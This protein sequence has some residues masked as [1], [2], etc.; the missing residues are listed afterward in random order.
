MSLALSGILADFTRR[1]GRCVIAGGAVRD[2]L[3]LR[4]PKDYDVFVMQESLNDG[5]ARDLET[6]TSPEWHKS[7]PFLQGTVRWGAAIVQVM[8]TK[9]TS[10]KDLVGDF[11]WNV[12]MFGFDDDGFY[13]GAPIED[14]ANGK[15]LKLNKV[16]FP[17]ST[18]RRGFRFSERFGMVLPARTLAD[19][20]E[21]A[22]DRL[23]AALAAHES[24]AIQETT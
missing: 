7:E 24:L 2:T 13:Q 11:D 12:S 5:W 22:A 19:L 15:E 4:E 3:L 6:V 17:V 18:L 9:H 10:L 14:V 16:T 23:N 20:C 8:L 21:Q 1:C